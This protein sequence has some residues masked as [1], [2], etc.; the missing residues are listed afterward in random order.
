MVMS[1]SLRTLIRPGSDPRD[2]EDGLVHVVL[3]SEAYTEEQRDEFFDDAE[4]LVR[5]CFLE[6][7]SAFHSLL[8]LLEVHALHVASATSTLP[9]AYEGQQPKLRGGGK[10]ATAFG[11][12]REDG[13]LRTVAPPGNP[14]RARA[15]ANQNT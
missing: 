2:V 5:E 3:V 13:P 15:L 14:S 1:P 12:R 11:L 8:P 4:R 10:A 9:L 7:E 6:A